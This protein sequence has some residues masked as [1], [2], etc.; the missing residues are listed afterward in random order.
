MNTEE[1]DKGLSSGFQLNLSNDGEEGD[2]GSYREVPND[3]HN[4]N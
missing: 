3:T 1:D 2:V 4:G